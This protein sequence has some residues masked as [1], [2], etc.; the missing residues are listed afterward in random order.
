[1][2]KRIFVLI[3]I[4]CIVFSCS[5]ATLAIEP[6]ESTVGVL[7]IFASNDGGSSSLNTSGHAFLAFKNTSSSS[8]T[9]GGLSVGSGHEITF[10]TWGNKSNHLGIW[11]NLESYFANNQGA[12]TNRVSL[13]MSVTQDDIDK[14]NTLIA[15]NDTWSALN[16]CSTFAA[17][18]WNA[19][20]S[21]TLSAGTPNTP[22]ALM[23]S[24]E[25]KGAYEIRRIVMDTIPIG[26]V[27]N[28]S[29][30]TVTMTTSALS[31]PVSADIACTEEGTAVFVVPVDMN[32][33]SGEIA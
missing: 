28:G 1:M 24:I 31:L 21:K 23:A 17:K 10:G 20:S 27:N 22:T 32:P 2:K 8:V 3:F 30:V 16:N 19:A 5:V 12:Y 29:F 33:S 9:V 6:R 14:I 25:S 11:Y 7:T 26:Y 18:I 15:N 13:S 4:I